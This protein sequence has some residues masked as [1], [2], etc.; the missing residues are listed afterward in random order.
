MRLY[1]PGLFL[2]KRCT[3]ECTLSCKSLG[4]EDITLRPGDAVVVPLYS[5]HRYIHVHY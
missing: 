1:P 3:Q 2:Q 4:A 5:I